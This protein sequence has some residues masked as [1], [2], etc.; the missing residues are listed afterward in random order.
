ML[1]MKVWPPSKTLTQFARAKSLQSALFGLTM[2]ALLTLMAS[3]CFGQFTEVDRATPDEGH[4]IL[5]REGEPIDTVEPRQSGSTPMPYGAHQS[6]SIVDIKSTQ[7]IGKHAATGDDAGGGFVSSS[8]Q[9]EEV[10]P[11]QNQASPQLRNNPRRRSSENLRPGSFSAG[12]APAFTERKTPAFTA[13]Q[14]SPSRDE[15]AVGGLPHIK[16][17]SAVTQQSNSSSDTII[18]RS[19]APAS[20]SAP[21]QGFQNEPRRSL[22]SLQRRQNVGQANRYQ[23]RDSQAALAPQN[24]QENRSGK[25][26]TSS[27]AK[28]LISRFG[29]KETEGP[30]DNLVPLRLVDVLNQGQMRGNRRQ[31]IDHYWETFDAWAQ[32]VSAKQHRDWLNGLRVSKS[33]EQSTIGVAKSNAQNEVTSTRIEF[34]KSQSKLMS[35]LGTRASIVPS[36]LPTVTMVKTNFQ[37]FKER[38]LIPARLETIDQTLKDLHDLVLSRADTVLLAE[39]TAEQVEGYYKSNRATIEQLLGAGRDWRS[40]EADFLAST[41]QYNKVYADYAMSLPYG[42]APVEQVVAMLV[43]PVKVAPT[44]AAQYAGGSAQRAQGSTT[45]AQPAS[46]SRSAPQGRSGNSRAAGQ[47]SRIRAASASNE[48]GRSSEARS[49]QTR[50]MPDFSQSSDVSSAAASFASPQTPVFRADSTASQTADATS[51]RNARSASASLGGGSTD[52]TTPAGARGNESTGVDESPFGR[53]KT[54]TPATQPST[55]PATRSAISSGNSGFEG[56]IKKDRGGF[57]AQANRSSNG[58]G[59]TANNVASGPSED[60]FASRSSANQPPVKPRSSFEAGGSANSNAFSGESARG[61]G[62]SGFGN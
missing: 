34:G 17:R 62:S 37:A 42:Q 7:S 1:E 11:Q 48:F 21:V 49:R 6:R 29:L 5:M 27:S 18:D 23:N 20:Y 12:Q 43:V 13:R 58:F 39:R 54:S 31:L 14:S 56:G 32:S 24:R 52:S 28:V 26:K 38:G 46:S 19:V 30:S 61:G 4:S 40:A 50:P 41:I 8:N 22:Q 9:P 59:R 25:K 10:S 44:V 35:I 47:D 60:P 2:F 55:Q 15:Q 53:R 45:P 57:N 3:N 51:R 33:T 36:D 16:N